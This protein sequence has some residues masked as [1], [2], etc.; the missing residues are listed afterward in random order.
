MRLRSKFFVFALLIHAILVVL[1]LLLYVQSRYLFLAAE[2]LILFSLAVTLHLYRSFL[3][4]LNVL[5]AGIESIK[6]KDFSTT[7]IRTGQEELDKLIDVYNRMIQELRGER[8]RQREQHYFL[9]RLIYATATG[10]VI[11]DLDGYVTMINPAAEV[12]LGLKAGEAVGCRLEQLPGVP[13]GELAGMEAGETRILSING[14]QTFKCRRSHFLDQGF[15]RHFILIEELTREIL[16]VQKQAYEKVIR[17]MSHEI[18]NS[19]GAINSILNSSR[20]YGDQL[21]ENDRVDF[22]DALQV[23]IDRNDGLNRFMSNF[24]D[25]VR[26]PPPAKV[27]YDV[28][29]LLQSSYVLMSAECEKRRI[30]WEWKL[31]RSPLLV[32]IDVQQMEQVVVN[33]IKNAIEAIDTDGTITVLT[34]DQPRMLK[35]IDTGNGI[36]P[37]QRTQLFTPFFST[38]KNG[39][40]IGL[41]LIREILINHGFRFNLESTGPGHTEFLVDFSEDVHQE[42]K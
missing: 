35:I 16:T 28:H 23:A 29:E 22:I 24:A 25:V 15:Y 7:F 41:T 34:T 21:T 9:E 30:S 36:T 33:I 6:D 37:E 10:V 5:A 39:Q 32:D 31:S 26:I 13:G 38:R 42:N 3:K 12:F 40:G 18:N 17:M 20:H 19:V 1:S 8:I 14:I 27:Q 11:L 4:P 2:L